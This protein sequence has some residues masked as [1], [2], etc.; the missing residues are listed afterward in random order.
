M[1]VGSGGDGGCGG[2]DGDD[3]KMEI[4]KSSLPNIENFRKFGTM[5]AVAP[6]TSCDIHLAKLLNIGQR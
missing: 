1:V 3:D 5:V 6:V 2:T 4:L